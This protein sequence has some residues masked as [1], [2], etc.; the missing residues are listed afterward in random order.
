[1][2][3]KRFKIV[4]FSAYEISFQVI[5]DIKKQWLFCLQF[6]PNVNNV[7]LIDT[8]M[9][10]D[11]GSIEKVDDLDTL[12]IYGQEGYTQWEYCAEAALDTIESLGFPVYEQPHNFDVIFWDLENSCRVYEKGRC[13]GKD[14]KIV[15]DEEEDES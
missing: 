5:Q 9:F 11:L 10:S 2:P 3:E 8:S 1:M 4:E 6:Y 15:T 13:N 12:L 7:G 14:F